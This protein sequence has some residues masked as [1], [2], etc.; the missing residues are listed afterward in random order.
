MDGRRDPVERLEMRG[1]VGLGSKLPSH[2]SF[3]ENHFVLDPH[4]EDTANKKPGVKNYYGPGSVC[5]EVLRA[6]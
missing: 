6:S 1:Y 2:V 3:Q 5:S 4:K